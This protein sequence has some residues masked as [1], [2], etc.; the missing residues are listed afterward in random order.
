LAE[1]GLAAFW[2]DIR[3]VDG[4]NTREEKAEFITA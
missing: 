4:T 1:H 3:I 2:L